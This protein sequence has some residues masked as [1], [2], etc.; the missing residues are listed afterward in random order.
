MNA[1]LCFKHCWSNP[2]TVIFYKSKSSVI[3]AIKLTVC[4]SVST[5]FTLIY[6]TIRKCYVCIYC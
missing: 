6:K 3:S 4:V 1:A 5:Y 2:Q